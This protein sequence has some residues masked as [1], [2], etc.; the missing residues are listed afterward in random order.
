MAQRDAS[1]GPS[2]SAASAACRSTVISC[3]SKASVEP[4][5]RDGELGQGGLDIPL[6]GKLEVRA[7]PLGRLGIAGV[8]GQHAGPSAGSSIAALELTRPDR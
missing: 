8:G 2:A 4:A 5:A 6:G 1:A 3:A 7:V